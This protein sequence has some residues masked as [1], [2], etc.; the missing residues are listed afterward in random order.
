[1]RESLKSAVDTG[2][3][4]MMFVPGMQIAA[5]GAKYLASDKGD[6]KSV[7]K[8]LDGITD[9]KETR[10]PSSRCSCGSGR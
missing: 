5:V 2:G 6:A 1:M 4:V 9:P 10:S 3:N 7:E 8:T